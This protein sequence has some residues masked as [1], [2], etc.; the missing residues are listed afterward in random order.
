MKA[1]NNPPARTALD[2]IKGALLKP[3]VKA[4]S[5]DIFDT[6]LVRPAL[7]PSDLFA[8]VGK[9]AGLACNFPQIRREAELAAREGRAAGREEVSLDD[10][11]RVLEKALGD[12]ALCS[13]LKQAELDVEA[14]YLYPRKAVRE[15]Y[16]AVLATGKEIIISSDMYLPKDFI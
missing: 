3:R 4:V 13:R 1:R 11:Y 5:F 7:S 2:G 16:A 9:R 15:I 8:L 12:S 14:D 10:I 6:L